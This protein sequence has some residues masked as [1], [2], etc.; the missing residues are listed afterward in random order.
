VYRLRPAYRPQF[1]FV[2]LQRPRQPL[3]CPSTSVNVNWASHASQFTVQAASHI[4]TMDWTTY[5]KSYHMWPVEWHHY[6]GLIFRK[7]MRHTPIID[8][9][10]YDLPPAL[11][12]FRR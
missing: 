5:S 12:K 2:D 9:I 1:T 7:V 8:L 10:N 3:D 11:L 4:L 6:P